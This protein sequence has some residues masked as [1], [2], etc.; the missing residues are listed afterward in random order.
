M[1]WKPPS[2][3]EEGLKRLLIPPRL[4]LWWRANKELLKGEKELGLLPFLVDRSRV[5]L[6]VGANKGVW[7]YLLAGLCRKVHAFEPNPKAFE[8]L[9]RGLAGLAVTQKLA[10]S[11]R[12]GV[13]DL[14]IPRRRRG[15]S[16]QGGSLSPA[17]VGS[18]HGS[19]TVEVA[20]LDGLG[21][22]DVGF[23]KIDVEGHE[24]AVLEGAR[25]TLRRDRPVLVIEMEER[26]VGRPLEE[27]V[28]EVEGY[29]YRAYALQRRVLT[30]FGNIDL[31][32]HHR[33]PARRGDYV[34]NFIFLPAEPPARTPGAG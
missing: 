23:M 13:A 26:H 25:N 3:F 21:I 32:R 1:S 12:N 28:A 27:M 22:D 17:S 6:D 30:A 10:L 2:T 8:L 16:N 11:N 31:D 5:A 7:A 15:Y 33:R 18:E 20:T 29:G 4:Y 14:R 34:F 9:R 24:L 19:V